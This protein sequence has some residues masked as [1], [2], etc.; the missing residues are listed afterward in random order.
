M[1]LFSAALSKHKLKFV[2][3]SQCPEHIPL[4]AKWA[5]DEWGYIRNKG[6]EY[7]KDV[8]SGM[9]EYVYI[10]TL[11]NQ[12]VAMF[13]LYEKKMC[14]E[15]NVGKHKAPLISELM[16]VYV[17]KPYR[18]LGFGQQIITAAKKQTK[19]VESEF[20]LL[21]TLKPGLNRFYEKNGAKVIAENQLFLHPTDVLAIRL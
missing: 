12:P 18:G 8:L 15:F 4:A 16:Y 10:G 17:D 5:E 19:L 20:I 9:K 7:R 21:D 13:V 6:V 3:L 11:Q 14:P 1:L 2:R